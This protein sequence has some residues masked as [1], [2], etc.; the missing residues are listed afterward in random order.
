MVLCAAPFVKVLESPLASED[1]NENDE[2]YAIK[3]GDYHYQI[4]DFNFKNILKL[5]AKKSTS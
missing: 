3:I 4:P 2:M 1:E 5:M